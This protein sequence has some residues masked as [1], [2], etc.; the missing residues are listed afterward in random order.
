[1]TVEIAG[2]RKKSKVLNQVMFVED[3][4]EKNIG[5]DCII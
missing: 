5:N 4:I 2:Q 1:L 3:A